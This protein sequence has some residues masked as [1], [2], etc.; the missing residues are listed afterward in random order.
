MKKKSKKAL[1]PGPIFAIIIPRIMPI[2]CRDVP[3]SET[4]I[5]FKVDGHEG[6]KIYG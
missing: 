4:R 1:L 6:T 5:L 2:G 3:A